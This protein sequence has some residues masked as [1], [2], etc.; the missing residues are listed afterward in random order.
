MPFYSDQQLVDKVKRAARKLDHTPELKP[1]DKFKKYEA[2]VASNLPAI[3]REDCVDY[4]NV[5]NLTNE[6][7]KKGE[8]TGN[9]KELRFIYEYKEALYKRMMMGK[10]PELEMVEDIETSE[11]AS[12]N[13][14]LD[15]C[16]CTLR[17]KA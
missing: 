3:A 17:L 11:D 6:L 15:F 12:G 2:D 16:T 10:P 9:K 7:A 13:E 5:R 14:E 1:V 4:L 8:I